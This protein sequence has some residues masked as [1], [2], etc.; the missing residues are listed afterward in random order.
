MDLL[1]K[2]KKRYRKQKGQFTTVREFAEFTGIAMSDIESH[3]VN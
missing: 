3:M 1:A 2:I